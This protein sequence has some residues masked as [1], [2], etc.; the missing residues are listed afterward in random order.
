LA[1]VI[2][3]VA[4]EPLLAT[5]PVQAPEAVHAVALVEDQVNV[6]LPPFETLVGL[7]LME[8]LGGVA[9]V[10]TVADW[11]AEPP[12]PVHVSV[13]FVVAERVA[14]ALEPLVGLVPLHPPDATQAVVLVDD[15]VNTDAAPLL[16]VL[17]LAEKVRA[18]AALV[19]DTVAD[20]VALPPEPVQVSP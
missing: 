4:C 3:P 2:A 19:T 1:A 20:C 6:E 13:N 16:T 8:T 18:G 14:V 10:V 12:A 11:D 5:A 15:Q 9:D 17:G 7:A